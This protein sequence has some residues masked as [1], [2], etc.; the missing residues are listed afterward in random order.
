MCPVCGSGSGMD[1][2]TTR[3]GGPSCNRTV[4]TCH[5]PWPPTV[6]TVDLL[7]SSSVSLELPVHN[8]PRRGVCHNHGLSPGYVDLC[9]TPSTTIRESPGTLSQEGIPHRSFQIQWINSRIL[10]WDLDS[11]YVQNTYVL[12]KY[13]RDDVYILDTT[14]SIY[15]VETVTESYLLFEWVEYPGK[16]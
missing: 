4:S 10:D 8:D 15:R 5:C 13:N 12:V 3:V 16:H 2:D 11:F 9:R 14:Y 1:W 6:F 7:F